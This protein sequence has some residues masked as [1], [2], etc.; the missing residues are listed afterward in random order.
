MVRFALRFLPGR[1][2]AIAEEIVQDALIRMLKGPVVLPTGE[3]EGLAVLCKVVE[4]TARN[5]RRSEEMRR[6]QLFDD[7]RAAYGSEVSFWGTLR[8]LEL[9]RDLD[10]ALESLTPGQRQVVEMHL[11]GGLTFAEVAEARGCAAK[12]AKEL[13]RRGR[14]KLM[15]ALK[16]RYGP[17]SRR[18]RLK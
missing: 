10:A 14:R 13:Y 18:I 9:R 11:V 15:E 2:E 1:E 5:R 4:N 8:T 17:R 6:M 3:Q 12:T 7:D 16:D